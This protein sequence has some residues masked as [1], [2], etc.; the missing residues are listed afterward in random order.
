MKI[1][2]Q[3]EYIFAH[4]GSKGTSGS[5]RLKAFDDNKKFVGYIEL[6][7]RVIPADGDPCGTIVVEG[8]DRPLMVD[9]VLTAD[10]QLPS[11]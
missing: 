7:G 3:V 1:T 6:E 11:V 8:F 9:M 10:L 5:T 2:F 4:K